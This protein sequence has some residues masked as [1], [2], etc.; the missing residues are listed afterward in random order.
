MRNLL[1]IALQLLITVSLTVVIVLGIS[2]VIELSILKQRETQQLAQQGTITADRIANGLALPLSR[3]NQAETNRVVQ[4]ELAAEEVTRIQVLDGRGQLYVGK[5]KTADGSLV[6]LNQENI[7]SQVPVSR[8]YSVQR[9]ITFKGNRIGTL[10]LDESSAHL[11]RELKK[12]GWGIAIKLLLLVI[13]LSVVLY[14]ALRVL[15]LRRLSL[16]QAWVEDP[17]SKGAPPQFRFSDEIN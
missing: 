15:I 7:P 3:M 8:D 2:S 12:L 16:L 1:S 9:D 10:Q 13:L 11:Q 4:D 5:V 17:E 6:D 14:V